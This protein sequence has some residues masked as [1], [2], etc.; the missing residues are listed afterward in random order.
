MNWKIFVYRSIG[1][2]LA[3]FAMHFYAG[4]HHMQVAFVP[5]ATSIVLVLGSPDA[6]AAQPRAVIGGHL[7]ST[8][9]GLAVGLIAGPSPHA[10]SIAVGLA[11]LAMF[12][13]RTMHPPAGIDP[14]IVVNDSMT[15][16]F[17][18]DPVL[19]GVLLLVGFA[20]IWHNAPFGER[21]WP[22]QWC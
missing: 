4:E 22:R 17:F 9:V 3:I 20:Y 7:I 21:H 12:A 6:T 13:T 2:G 19:F 11:I 16:T 18:F 15:W 5:F 8:L 14:L 10:A 1:G